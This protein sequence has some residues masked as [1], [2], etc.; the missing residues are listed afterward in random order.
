[1][2]SSIKPYI[3]CIISILVFYFLLVSKRIKQNKEKDILEITKEK[4]VYK[5]FPYYKTNKGFLRKLQNSENKV[6][7][8][9]RRNDNQN[10]QFLGNYDE[11]LFYDNTPPSQVKLNNETI[12]FSNNYIPLNDYN[13]HTIEIIWN[14]TLT[15][16]DFMFTE[17]QD[18]EWIDFSNFDFSQ[19]T[20]ANGLV[21]LCSKLKYV[22]FGNGNLSKVESIESMFMDCSS[23]ETV[24][25][26]F[27]T[28]NVKSI[29]DFFS[30]CIS[31]KSLDLSNLYTPSLSS[32]MYAF[33]N[34]ISLETIEL[35]NFDNSI[36]DDGE[37]N[38]FNIFGNCPKLKYINL[39]NYAP[40]LTNYFR[41]F[42]PKYYRQFNYLYSKL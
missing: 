30:G 22:N 6:T 26:F 42:R 27:Q 34:C 7:I 19:V 31:L 2:R 33:K 29:K 5:I 38:A 10:V 28:L 1:M 16:L 24:D 15:S 23:L 4:S 12:S 40:L 3:I 8:K 17:C 13:L 32:M 39:L 11:Y 20:S 9:I 21:G 35:P 37:P 18:I 41:F 14:Y 25:N 36:I